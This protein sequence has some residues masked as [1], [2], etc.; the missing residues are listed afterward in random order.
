MNKSKVLVTGGCGFIGSKIVDL[1]VKEGHSVVVLDNMTTGHLENISKETLQSGN[2]NII[3]GDI[4]NYADLVS[5][6]NKV[7]VIC[8]QAALT[9]VPNSFKDKEEYLSVNIE[10]TNKLL[11]IA[12]KRG[13]G[14]VV[15]ASSA[16]VY[17]DSIFVK[18]SESRE[19]YGLSSPYAWSKHIN[20][21]QALYYNTFTHLRVMALRYFNVYGEGQSINGE[22]AV[23]PTFASK[24]LKN[25]PIF[26]Y[27]DGK[28]YRDFIHVKDVARANYAAMQSIE[29]GVFNVGTSNCIS[30]N[31]LSQELTTRTGYT[32]KIQ[33]KPARKGDI[34][35]SCADMTETIKRLG[36]K[37]SIALYSP[38]GLDV[39]VESLK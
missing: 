11:E 28:Q 26:I 14:S 16:A 12:N 3:N 35:L 19:A 22:G 7:D 8:H 23:I 18:Q 29:K 37:S 34:W 2:V 9:S 10:G 36:F 32:E 24:M 1:L 33:Y 17:G 21:Q 15:L 30:I 20:E 6:T 4:R 31:E 5:A 25:Q 27:G 39:I 38:E 13:I